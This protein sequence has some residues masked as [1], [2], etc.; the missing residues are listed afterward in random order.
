MNAKWELLDQSLCLN[1]QGKTFRPE[2]GEIF[3]YLRGDMTTIQSLTPEN[4]NLLNELIKPNS[5]I[6][7]DSFIDLDIGNF[8][9]SPY[10]KLRLTAN[11][12]ER[13]EIIGSPKEYKETDHIVANGILRPLNPNEKEYFL[14][15]F[16]KLGIKGSGEITL[17]QYFELKISDLPIGEDRCI[18]GLEKID[19]ITPNENEIEE[20]FFNFEDYSLFPYQD[21]GYNWLKFHCESGIGTVLADEMGL[22]KTIQIIRLI[23]NRLS[24]GKRPS[25]VVVPLSLIQNW[26]K[27][28]LKFAPD[29]KVYKH[30]GSKRTG[31]TRFLK[32]QDIVL[33][34]YETVTRDKIFLNYTDWDLVV[35]D[36]AQYIRN[37]EAQRSLAIKELKREIGIAVTGTPFENR[38]TDLWSIL[39]FSFPGYLGDLEDFKN[40]YEEAVCDAEQLERLIS[41]LILRRKTEEVLDDLP[42][43]TE[44]DQAITMSEYESTLYERTRT[45]IKG[46]L[47][48]GTLPKLPD[49]MP[50][51]K[52]C[53]HSFIDN[54]SRGEDPI[55]FSPKYERC[56]QIL[57][58]SSVNKRKTIIFTHWIKMIKMMRS[59]L[60]MRFNQAYVDFI[61]G[62]VPA[63]ER[64][65]KVDEFNEFEGSA[66]LIMNYQTG[67][68]GLNLQGADNV[69]LYNPA[70]NPAVED[71]AIKRAHRVGVKHPVK[72]FRLYYL[73]TVEDVMRDILK[74]KRMI[75]EAALHGITNEEIEENNLLRS[76]DLSPFIATD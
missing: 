18:E 4:D 35:L 56:V 46:Q 32:T 53:A 75:G 41:P 49:L 14:D 67:A 50:L 70:W 12:I 17:R 11:L 72:A 55:D 21:K 63:E 65:Q 33:S 74:Q 8:P 20:V 44:I 34:S 28:I 27:E 58:E 25:L 39:D 62:S 52:L 57:Y 9:N 38:L 15:E 30:I 19:G 3:N 36:E 26:K 48:D 60:K 68:T 1:Y 47:G 59:D 76:L 5:R 22:G 51:R 10:L 61:D 45:D 42:E 71:Q 13:R 64:Q 7:V 6:P 16:E 37:P 40:T 29:L 24:A 54:P 69:I 23:C 66:I 43:L 73:H 2:I 31:D